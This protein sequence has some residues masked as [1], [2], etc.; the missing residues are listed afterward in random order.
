MGSACR[1]YFFSGVTGFHWI[2]IADSSLCDLMNLF[3]EK[4][5]ERAYANT[6]L[7]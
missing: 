2:F 3:I 5:E 7:S 1:A 6:R 4:V